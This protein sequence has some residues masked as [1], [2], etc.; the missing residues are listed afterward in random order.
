[1]KRYITGSMFAVAVASMS[2]TAAAQS[3]PAAQPQAADSQGIAD[4]VVTAQRR[5]ESVQRASISIEAFSGQEIANRG[6]TRPDDLTKIATGVQVGGGTSTQIYVRG[7]GDFGVVA[8]ANPAVVT[9]LDGVPISRPQAISGNFFDLDRIELLKGP[10][11]TLYGRNASGGA[12]NLI[13]ARPRLNKTEGYL[14][15]TAG[16]YDTLGGEG[17]INLPIADDIAVRASFQLSDRGGY[18][19]DGG[20]DDKHQS[21]RLQALAKFDR[22]SVHLLGGYTHLGGKGSGLAVLPSIPGQ[23]PWTGTTSKA[24]ADYYFS[25][26]NANFVASGGSSPPA[27][28]FDRPDSERLFQNVRSWNISGQADYDFGGAILTVIPAYRRTTAIFSVSPGFNYSPGGK[29]TKGETSDQYSLETRLG[30]T[31]GKLKW[32]IGAFAFQENQSTDFAITAGVIQRVRIA[33]DLQ[34]KSIAGFGE[35]TYSLTDR[36]RL[37]GGLRYTSDQRSQTNFRKF[38]ISPTVTGSPPLATPCVPPTFAPGTECNL[39]PPVNFDSSR[40]FNRATWKVGGE[41]DLAPQSM[42][43]ATVS[44]GFKAGGFNQAVDTVATNRALPFK[45]ETITAYTVGLRNRFLHNTLQFNL[46]GFYW[47]YRDLQLSSLILDGSGNLSLTTQNAGKARIYGFN[48]DVVAKP[49]AGTTLHAGVEY[50]NSRYQEFAFVQAAQFTTPGSTGCAVS[51]A[52]IPPGPLGPYV[53]VNCAGKPL[54]RSPK[55]SGNVGMTQVFGLTNGANVTFDTDLAF[56]T[57]RYTSTSFVPNSLAGAYGNWN[58]TLTYNAPG[59]RWFIG[60]YVRN[61]TNAT[62]YTGGG[63]DQSPFV[64]GFVSSTIGAPRTYGARFGLRF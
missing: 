47:D 37:I 21:I 20:D 22:L 33:S 62:V 9:N 35:A 24:A 40:T 56:A 5:S 42:L 39:L 2:G 7:V 1:M 43:F 49:F 8:T 61:I 14:Q 3:Q 28:V 38:A 48:A 50:V 16:N 36:L 6:V 51:P 4:I 46:E 63:G 17:A 59:E 12:L 57:K 34:S 54:V 19:T 10:Q 58:A 30:G 32:V 27:A 11:G 25:V 55:V 26:I 44:T 52:S 60:G 45:A 13:A 41:V 64:N 15:G 29:G 31:S 23:S 53:T 18:L